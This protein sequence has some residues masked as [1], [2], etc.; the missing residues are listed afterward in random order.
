MIIAIDGPAAS[1]KGTLAR[2]LAKH[3]NYAYLDTGALYRTVAKIVLD[4]GADPA[5]EAAAHE[6][7]LTLQKMVTPDLLADPA[8]RNDEVGNAAA[9]VAAIPA[10]RQALLDL[11]RNFAKNPPD[12]RLGVVLDGRDIG[13]VICPDAQAKLFIVA[14]PEIRAQRRTKELQAKGLNVTY[15]AVLADMRARDERDAG[16]KGAPLKPADDA[17]VLD[18]TKLSE[19]Q[20]FQAALDLIKAR[21]P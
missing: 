6:A 1:G 18:T 4:A 9:K 13:T 17:V 19:Q 8:I 2:N 16:R 10:V 14:D 3:L 12:Q 15:E 11:Q 5:N 20:V 21:T 7:A